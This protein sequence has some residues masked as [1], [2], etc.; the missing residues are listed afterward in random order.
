MSMFLELERGLS[1]RKGHQA[2]DIKHLEEI[3]DLCY[4][5]KNESE[6]SSCR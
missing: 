5:V 1:G 2:D 3:L 4:N 6:V